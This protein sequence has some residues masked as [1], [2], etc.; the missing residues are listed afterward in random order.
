MHLLLFFFFD[1]FSVRLTSAL[2]KRNIDAYRLS[3]MI[4]V[5]P[6]TVK[7]WLNGRFEPR[8]RNLSRISA[9]LNVSADYLI[10]RID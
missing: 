8:H 10:G 3:R 4:Q 6:Y 7:R 5:S 9:A 2:E 1:D